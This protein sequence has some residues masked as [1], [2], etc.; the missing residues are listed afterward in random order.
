MAAPS[1]VNRSTTAF[2]T[3]LDI[4]PFPTS[5]ADAR[6][7][8]STSSAGSSTL[9]QEEFTPA[10]ER[11]SNIPS[12]V[13]TVTGPV[14]EPGLPPSRPT[15]MDAS[16]DSRGALRAATPPFGTRR[17]LAA[18]KSGSSLRQSV[19]AG[20][21]GGA[22]SR[23]GS[24]MS[25][26]RTHV[27]SLVAQGFHNPMSGQKLQAQRN[28]VRP[29]SS[30][31]MA[32]NAINS[33]RESQE[34]LHR[35]RYSDA[36]VNT[37]R[38]GPV[39]VKAEDVPPLPTSR[40]TATPADEALRGG[41][42]AA[43]VASYNSQAPLQDRQAPTNSLRIQ[44]NGGLRKSTSSLH[45][46]KSPKS[47][48]AS[49][50]LGSRKTS[51]HDRRPS[52]HQHEKLHSNPS[53]PSAAEKPSIPATS[54]T[55][56]KGKTKNYEYF[57]GNML[58]CCSGRLL[59]NRNTR[60]KPPLH[61]MTLI[62]TILPC[63]LFF[64]FSAPWLWHHVSPAL[65]LVFAYVFFLTISS[66]LH[67]ALSDPGILPRNLH[68]HPRNPEE[69]RDP[70]TVGPATTEWVMVK[71]FSS[72]SSKRRQTPG[73]EGGGEAELGSGS[74][75][76]EVPTKYCKS[77]SIWRPPRAHHCRVCDACVETQD[78]HCVW[79]NNC[80]GRRNYRYFFGYVAF[81][82]VLA[83]LLVAFSLTHVG[84][85]ARRHGM[86]W[87]E[88]ISVR[89]G[90]PQ[91]QV[92]FAMFIIAVL[93]LPY[94]GSLFLYHLFLTARGESTREYL[95]SHKFQLKDRYRPF[96]QASWYRNW[97]SVLARPRPPT[98]MQFK[99]EYV[100]GDVRFGNTMSKRERMAGMKGRYSLPA[101]GKGV[102]GPPG[103]GGSGNGEKQALEMKALPPKP[104]SPTAAGGFG[105][106]STP[107]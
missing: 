72:A 5:N 87:G 29:G 61:I 14:G 97:I 25:Q 82:S 77:C 7:T 23:P 88:V 63:A 30:L 90:R 54:R 89:R 4:D 48:K 36:S 13:L 66:F 106:N 31:A 96:T 98:Y 40:G 1:N 47:L 37:L 100:E 93:A 84:I 103:R 51:S 24:A 59:N 79:L 78:H 68:P 105:T 50:G 43:S 17:G 26:N 107:R 91:E 86:S 20:S 42:T 44:T 75:A 60:A 85:Y 67:A 76:M 21:D 57:A 41:H 35:H 11:Q 65:P 81:G 104:P 46:P 69:E 101:G 55:K 94:P 64:G 6:P 95:N 38:D 71:T 52:P 62:I 9:G 10:R 19:D 70:L 83:L 2:P 49:L 15:S 27:P 8:S 34:S 53:S 80:V 12:T 18:F 39:A 74:T 58:F 32:Q 3:F 73:G 92:A 28:S 102:D 33:Q 22:A 56:R 45:T 16:V 99:R